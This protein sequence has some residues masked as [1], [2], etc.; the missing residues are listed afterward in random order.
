MCLLISCSELGMKISFFN[1]IKP[2]TIVVVI[3]MVGG[4]SGLSGSS[5]EE[6]QL[7]LTERRVASAIQKKGRK[8]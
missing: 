5:N 4:G 6:G 1:V 3:I 7:F 8:R 2:S